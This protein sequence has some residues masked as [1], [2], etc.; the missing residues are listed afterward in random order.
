MFPV[1]VPACGCHCSHAF[2]GQNK[3]RGVGGPD[4]AVS[5][6]GKG[7]LE[8]CGALGKGGLGGLI[9]CA[10]GPNAVRP[11]LGGLVGGWVRLT[12]SSPDESDSLSDSG[13]WQLLN[14][15]GIDCVNFDL[16]TGN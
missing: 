4:G 10:L 13:I 14:G 1:D 7:A 16:F 8:P 15:A 9:L 12:R 6:F 3:Y 11:G 2:V 5:V